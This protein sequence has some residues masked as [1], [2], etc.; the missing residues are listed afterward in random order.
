MPNLQWSGETPGLSVLDKDSNE[1]DRVAWWEEGDDKYEL[2][3]GD[4]NPI[5]FDNSSDA[6]EAYAD[7]I[8]DEKYE[9]EPRVV[10]LLCNGEDITE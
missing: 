10:R 7:A 6:R 9:D 5:T 1:I 2:F 8:E 4:D 3:V